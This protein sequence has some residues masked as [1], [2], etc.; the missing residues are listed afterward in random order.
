MGFRC[1]WRWLGRVGGWNGG[2]GQSA[3]IWGQYKGF[4]LSFPVYG[5]CLPLFL[6]GVMLFAS[7]MQR[8]IWVQVS[9]RTVC[10][11]PARPF[12]ETSD[13]RRAERVHGVDTFLLL[14]D[15]KS[16]RVKF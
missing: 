4:L 1:F 5:L 3:K 12:Y 16:Y 15:N 7:L 13:A 8:R 11:L 6:R 9:V 2:N 10:S 14:T